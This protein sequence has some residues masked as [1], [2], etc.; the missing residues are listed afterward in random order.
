MFNAF[1]N[2][3]VLVPNGTRARIFIYELEIRMVL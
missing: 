3:Q 2:S 1:K